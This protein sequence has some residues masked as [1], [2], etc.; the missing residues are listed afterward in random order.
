MD[1]NVCGAQL[2][3]TRDIDH[4]VREIVRSID[5]A[6]DQGADILLTPEGSLSGYTP[7][8][9]RARVVAGLETVTSRARDRD[10]GLALGTCFIEDD[11]L[12]YNQIRFYAKDGE[13]LGFHSK[14]L[15]CGRL[16]PEPRGEMN[17]YAA[18]SLRTFVFEGITIGG[19]I[20]NDFWANPCCTPQPDP[21]LPHQLARMG[22]RIIFQ[23]V[24]GGRDGSA[25]SENVVWTFH[26]SNLL[27][28]TREDDLWTVVADSAH[29]VTMP[30]SCPSGV[31]SPKGEWAVQAK[32]QGVDHYSFC[33]DLKPKDEEPA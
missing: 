8:F 13:Y 1:L 11:D 19:L 30:C 3:V 22:A 25:W 23:A 27:M 5:R 2:D 21:Y 29:P 12:C 17:D 20:C 33:I 16:E 26:Q 28:R 7:D 4:N 15:R 10:V 32:R 24:N 31:I 18:R 14:I 6:K 9:D